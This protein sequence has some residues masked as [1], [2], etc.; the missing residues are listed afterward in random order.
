M[1]QESEQAQEAWRAKAA[2]EYGDSF[3]I[4][5]YLDGQKDL[6]A[7]LKAEIEKE[8]G[9]L[10]T[11]IKEAGTDFGAYVQSCKADISRLRRFLSL[12]DTVT[13]IK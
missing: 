11:A 3:V 5:F 8:I 9:E 10:E 4:P 12:L 13:P 7:A 2:F 1:S 6:R